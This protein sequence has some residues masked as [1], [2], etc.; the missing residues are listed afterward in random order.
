MLSLLV[1]MNV[2]GSLVSVVTVETSIIVN[3]VTVPWSDKRMRMQQSACGGRL[4]VDRD[5]LSKSKII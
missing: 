4:W 2:A 3:N 1:N 5:P